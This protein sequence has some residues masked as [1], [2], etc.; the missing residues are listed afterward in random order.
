MTPPCT[1]IV[2]IE[3][4]KLIGAAPPGRV[5]DWNVLSQIQPDPA[6]S[7]ELMTSSASGSAC[8]RG[9]AEIITDWL[10]P[11][12]VVC[13][14][15]FLSKNG[16]GLCQLSWLSTC[17]SSIRRGLSVIGS[18]WSAFCSII[19]IGPCRFQTNT[20]IHTEII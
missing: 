20:S 14:F 11:A 13:F 12:G 18:V 19:T 15:I 7:I 6:L 10:V 5:Q 8:C 3:D 16:G 1:E 17:F 9:A 4:K 2:F